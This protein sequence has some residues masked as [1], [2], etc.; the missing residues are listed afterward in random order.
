MFEGDMLGESYRASHQSTDIV[1]EY[2][3]TFE[4]GYC[5]ALWRKVEKPL[6]E[7]IL[8]P[9]GGRERTI[10]DFRLWDRP[11]C[12]ARSRILRLG[13]RRRCVGSYAVGSFSARQRSAAVYRHYA[14][15]SRTDI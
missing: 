12:K 2:I 8:R 1:A 6:L 7:S 14:D 15:P 5:A 9:L 10:L 13:C 4:V 3:S 11:H